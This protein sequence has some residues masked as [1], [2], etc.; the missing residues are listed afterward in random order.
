MRVATVLSVVLWCAPAAA[1]DF[2]GFYAGVNAGYAGETGRRDAH[3][4][5]AITGTG[6]AAGDGTLP[7]S[8]RDAA[9]AIRAG[10]TPVDKTPGDASD[11]R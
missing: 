10:R 1:E 5:G 4:P 7:P 8:V 9:R 2:T 3:R 11:R 6:S